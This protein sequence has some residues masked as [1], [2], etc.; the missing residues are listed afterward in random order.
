MHDSHLVAGRFVPGPYLLT[1]ARGDGS[2]LFSQA[3]I[4]SRQLSSQAF[5]DGFDVAANLQKLLVHF[6]SELKKLRFER[7][8]A[9]GERRDLSRQLLQCL[10]LALDSGDS[11]G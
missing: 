6:D 8:D 3:V 11:I 7:G 4:D 9:C 5:I 10:H 1:Q 2:Q